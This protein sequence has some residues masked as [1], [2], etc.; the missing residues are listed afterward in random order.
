MIP[1]P[2]FIIALLS[3]E[4]HNVPNEQL[5]S[6]QTPFLITNCTR[7]EYSHSK[8]GVCIHM[9]YVTPWTNPSI[10]A[11]LQTLGIPIAEDTVFIGQEKIDIHIPDSVL[12]ALISLVEQG[13]STP[14]DLGPIYFYLAPEKVSLNQDAPTR[15]NPTTL[16]NIPTLQNFH[17]NWYE[18]YLRLHMVQFVMDTD[19]IR[20][21]FVITGELR[22]EESLI[23][24]YGEL[25]Q[26]HY[27]TEP[28]TTQRIKEVFQIADLGSGWVSIEK[29]ASF[30]QLIPLSL[31]FFKKNLS[32]ILSLLKNA[33]TQG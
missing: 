7:G 24:E 5:M 9:T 8:S 10:A 11:V 33:G 16:Q 25:F 6:S 13:N 27:P 1:H 29:D 2:E 32:A 3:T 17:Y 4:S 14:T 31:T 15:T 22:R 21:V 28:I 26:V 30:F 19:H 18:Q 12:P 23:E 20:L